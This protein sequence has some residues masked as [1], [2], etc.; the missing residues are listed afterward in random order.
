MRSLYCY[1]HTNDSLISK[2][3]TI[4]DSDPFYFDSPFVVRYEYNEMMEWIKQ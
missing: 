3:I 1:L 4:V 2:P